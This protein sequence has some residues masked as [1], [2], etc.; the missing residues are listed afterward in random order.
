MQKEAK[1]TEHRP[2]AQNAVQRTLQPA[3]QFAT[4]AKF[5]LFYA[6]L[7]ATLVA[8]VSFKLSLICV[9]WD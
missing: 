9:L 2:C 8:L 1:K 5:C 4:T 3:L 6:F 7:L